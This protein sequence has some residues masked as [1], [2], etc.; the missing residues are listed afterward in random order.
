MIWYFD[1][2][3]TYLFNVILL[4]I[5]EYIF[6]QYE[7]IIISLFNSSAIIFAFVL[8]SSCLLFLVILL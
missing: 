1:Y 7:S 6:F 5:N 4:K 2:L 8:L 3:V